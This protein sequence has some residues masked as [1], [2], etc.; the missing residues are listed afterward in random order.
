MASSG[1]QGSS[2]GSGGSGGVIALYGVWVAQALRTKGV[3]VEELKVLRDQ[4]HAVVS[5]QG[6]LGAALA[7]LDRE[8]E[9]RGGDKQGGDKGRGGGTAQRFV[10]H[11]AGVP[12]DEGQTGRIEKRLGEVMLEELG[13]I[14][15]RGDFVATP[16]SQVETW[17]AGLGGRTPGIYIQMRQF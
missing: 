16:L 12:L 3:S 14:D 1:A 4:V 6:D 13:R 11:V 15:N 8:I 5:T 2:G 9:K 17:G 7:E 10:V